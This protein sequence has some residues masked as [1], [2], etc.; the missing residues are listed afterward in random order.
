MVIPIPPIDEQK[1]IVSKVKQ[2]MSWCDELEKKI[3]KRD[4]YQDKMMQA[5]VKQ[6]FKTDKE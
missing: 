1:E 5:V 6:A 3:D 4:V 2:L